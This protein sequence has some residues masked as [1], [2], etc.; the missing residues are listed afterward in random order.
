M[1]WIQIDVFR[2]RTCHSI[3]S[4]TW[5]CSCI[6]YQDRS[7]IVNVP[8]SQTRLKRGLK[9]CPWC[10]IGAKQCETHCGSKLLPW[11]NLTHLTLFW[12]PEDLG[13]RGGK[14]HRP[15]WPLKSAGL[16]V[17]DTS[18]QFGGAP[19]PINFGSTG[20]K[21]GGPATQ[22]NA[23]WWGNDLRD[24]DDDDAG[25]WW[26]WWRKDMVRVVKRLVRWWKNGYTHRTQPPQ[27]T[28]VGLSADVS[29]A[30]QGVL[31]FS[32]MKFMRFPWE[33]YRCSAWS[34]FDFEM[35]M[36]A[37]AVPHCCAQ[38]APPTPRSCIW[39][40]APG[41]CGRV[42]PSDRRFQQR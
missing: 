17:P 22:L 38:L 37:I 1:C 25:W 34:P 27:P 8:W 12:S 32:T 30:A 14:N 9:P 15:T 20:R 16:E 33:K 6:T 19:E 31:S 29:T 10:E 7:V 28:S 39:R 2:Y 40:G 13:S 23:T 4:R 42:L 21:P 18:S 41:N 36:R 5:F 35:A 3:V 26:W 11:Y 24:D